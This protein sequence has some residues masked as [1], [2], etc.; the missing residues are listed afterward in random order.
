MEK[1]NDN[2]LHLQMTVLPTMPLQL[3]TQ[4]LCHVNVPFYF[5]ETTRFD[6]V[7]CQLKDISDWMQ[8][9]V[10]VL[11]EHCSRQRNEL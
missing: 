4:R 11:V 8:L 1:L 10:F 9:S 2:S 5:T 6:S 3:Q 7:F